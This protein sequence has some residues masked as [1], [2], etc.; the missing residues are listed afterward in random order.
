VHL[1]ATR[2]KF[3]I[4]EDRVRGKR[5]A[6]R[7]SHLPKHEHDEELKIIG[8]I[9]ATIPSSALDK[10]LR[11]EQTEAILE[12]IGAASEDVRNY[13]R[14]VLPPL[15]ELSEDRLARASTYLR[16]GTACQP[17]ESASLGGTCQGANQVTVP[18]E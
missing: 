17:Y 7:Q 6:H 5:L 8:T 13:S 11:R 10:R 4:R 18:A 9:D 12:L 2:P 15:R 14:P 1:D 16:K 3:V